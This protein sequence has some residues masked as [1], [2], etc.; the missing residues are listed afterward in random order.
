MLGVLTEVEVDLLAKPGSPLALFIGF[1]DES[2]AVAFV[3]RLRAESRSESRL[4]A[5][6]IEWFD[7][8]SLDLIVED[9]VGLAIEPERKVAIYLEQWRDE[10]ETLELL[11]DAW[12]EG[13]TAMGISD[14]DRVRVAADEAQRA[15]LLRARHAVPSGVNERAARHGMTKMG[16]D[17]AVADA[18]LSDVMALYWQARDEPLRL[19][20]EGDA[21]GGANHVTTVTFGHV[22]DNHLHMNF[23][24]KTEAE[25]SLAE[26]IKEELTRRVIAWGGSPS[27]EHGIGKLKR[28]A[29]RQR[30]GEQA[31]AEMRAT[32]RAFDPKEILGRGNLFVVDE[33]SSR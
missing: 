18:R 5:D 31:Y 29:L 13:L 2:L 19:L 12:L 21:P 7:R 27:A 26:R 4:R 20:G 1:D 25:R 3:E 8:A 9:G 10:G 30:V 28:A 6:C 14:L 24:P 17:C 16:T 15:Q 33:G 11:I 32:R 22:G 23:L